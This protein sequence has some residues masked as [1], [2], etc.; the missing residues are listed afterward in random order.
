ML[1][2]MYWGGLD[3]HLLT[4]GAIA[5]PTKAEEYASRP[6][7][8]LRDWQQLWAAWDTVTKAMTPH[9]ELLSKPIKL[10]NDLI[11]YHG[12][13]PAFA[14]MFRG[15]LESLS[16][17]DTHQIYRSQNLRVGSQSSQQPMQPSLSVGSTLMLIIRSRATTT[18]KSLMRG[19]H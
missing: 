18:A 6:V 17:S 19:L 3:L 7:P 8:S 9:E 12:H 2:V 5:Y 16:H 15:K 1:T 10:R 14:G 4:P 13:I 11:F